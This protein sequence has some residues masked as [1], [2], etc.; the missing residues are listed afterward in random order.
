MFRF[1]TGNGCPFVLR[2]C[3]PRPLMIAML[4]D[5]VHAGEA[6]SPDRAPAHRQNLLVLAD[7]YW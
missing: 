2:R 4:H 7:V 5:I 6:P 3:T 1:H